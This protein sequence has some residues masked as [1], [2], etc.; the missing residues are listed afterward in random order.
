[1]HGYAKEATLRREMAFSAARNGLYGKPE[2]S[3]SQRTD[4]QAGNLTRLSRITKITPEWE[5]GD[6]LARLHH[7]IG[8]A[9]PFSRLF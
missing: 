9:I 6:I 2:K 3:I 8:I 5:A 1:M 4:Y 7:F